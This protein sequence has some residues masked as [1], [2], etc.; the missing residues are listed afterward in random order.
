[1]GYYDVD[2]LN[3]IKPVYEDEVLRHIRFEKD[4]DIRIDG[5]TNRGVIMKPE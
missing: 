3:N 4:I 1:E 2:Y 5:R